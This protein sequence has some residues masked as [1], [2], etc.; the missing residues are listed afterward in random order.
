M[1]EDLSKKDEKEPKEE[2]SLNL[3]KEEKN[4]RQIFPKRRHTKRKSKVRC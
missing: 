1:S 4:E 2:I 3:E